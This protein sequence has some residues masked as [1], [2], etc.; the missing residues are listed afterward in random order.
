LPLWA[1]NETMSFWGVIQ[2]SGVV[3]RSTFAVSGGGTGQ[4]SSVTDFAGVG[5]GI[6][7]ISGWAY[8]DT[9]V[10]V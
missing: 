7:V 10:V 8:G 2:E 9:L 4:A 6:S 1:R 5:G 3:T